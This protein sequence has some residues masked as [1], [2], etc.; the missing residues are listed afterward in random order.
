M[1]HQEASECNQ[2]QEEA[3][4]GRGSAWTS[5]SEPGLVYTVEIHG[6]AWLVRQILRLLLSFYYKHTHFL[7]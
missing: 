5:Q 1:S 3:A 6:L 7:G 2:G 4:E